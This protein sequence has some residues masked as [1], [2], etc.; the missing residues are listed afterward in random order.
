M[1]SEAER[2]ILAEKVLTEVGKQS[3]RIRGQQKRLSGFM[4][5]KGDLYDGKLMV[6]GR[7]TNGWKD[8]GVLPEE[9][10]PEAAGR[11]LLAHRAREFETRERKRAVSHEVGQ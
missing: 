8:K 4:A 10:T 2:Q 11:A 6:V 1:A 7:A 5:V 3:S 9:L